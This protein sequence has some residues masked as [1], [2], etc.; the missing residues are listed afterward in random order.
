MSINPSGHERVKKSN[1]VHFPAA[2]RVGN[3]EDRDYRRDGR[4]VP[5]RIVE[6][7]RLTIDRREK[8]GGREISSLPLAASGLEF[9]RPVIE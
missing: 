3:V 6:K 1:E 5:T 2:S 4:N 7:S 9:R 8:T